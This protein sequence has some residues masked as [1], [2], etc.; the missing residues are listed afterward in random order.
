MNERFTIPGNAHETPNNPV[1]GVALAS[2]EEIA[3][4]TPTENEQDQTA[5]NEAV[6]LA[7]RGVHETL[8][9]HDLESLVD[10]IDFSDVN[11]HAFSITANQLKMQDGV[12]RAGS[13]DRSGHL[14]DAMHRE[15]YED[16]WGDPYADANS[17][18]QVVEKVG[19]RQV[20]RYIDSTI[21]SVPRKG[22]LGKMG[23][24]KQ[25]GTP[26]KKD[27]PGYVFDYSFNSPGEGDEDAMRAGHY[28]GQAITLSVELTKEQ[29]TKLSSILAE[30]PKAAR[31]ILDTF[32]QTTG[33]FGT[34][35]AELY[36]DE[37]AFHDPDEKYNGELLARDVRP[38]Y[39]AIPDIEPQIVGLIGVTKEPSL[40]PTVH[41]PAA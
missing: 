5:H 7:L 30:N 29:A 27:E 41:I 26:R 16:A 34:W 3:Q 23:L 33:D 17:Q 36:D 4:R 2:P 24:K 11:K 13:S 38:N 12:L 35:N 9:T 19:I 32:V 31:H 6:G 8:D 18:H 15:S 40:R 22:L 21:R 20:D 37:G 28:N 39:G 25:V 14:R 10:G 1:E